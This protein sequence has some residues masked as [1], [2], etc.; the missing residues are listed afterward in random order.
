M[1]PTGSMLFVEE[2]KND[3]GR[4]DIW[5]NNTGHNGLAKSILELGT[6]GVGSGS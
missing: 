1:I 6:G 5:I 4:I 2:V 3:L